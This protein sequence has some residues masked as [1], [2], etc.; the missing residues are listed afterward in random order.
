MQLD[1]NIDDMCYY[2]ETINNNQLK[3]VKACKKEEY[4]LKLDNNVIGV[5]HNSSLSSIKTLEEDCTS[6]YECQNNLVC[7]SK[8]CIVD[9]NDISYSIKDPS[10]EEKTY[11]Y[12]T[13]EQKPFFIKNDGKYKCLSKEKFGD[14]CYNPNAQNEKEVFPDYFKVCGEISLEDKTIKIADIGSLDSKINVDDERACKSGFA[15]YFENDKEFGTDYSNVHNKIYKVCVELNG[16]E[17]RGDYCY[18]NYTRDDESEIYNLNKL[19]NTLLTDKYY[20]SLEKDCQ[21]L[22]TKISLFKNYIKKLENKR[23]NCINGKKYYHEPFT[24]GDDELRLLWYEY[25]H[26]D[27]YLLY[28][29][30][31]DIIH[32]LVKEAYPSYD[33]KYTPSKTEEEKNNN[34][35]NRSLTIKNMIILLILL[36]F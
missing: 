6:D 4:C 5:C 31:E 7:P 27:E 10:N 14:Y 16:V 28:K 17:K 25:N 23:D 29:N 30:E 35:S 2:T 13:S 36:L 33:P 8:K 1:Y 24:C 34:N 3:Y 9:S 15:L 21:Y 18:I 32:F 12:C 22:T 19:K 20:L 11:Y 26:P